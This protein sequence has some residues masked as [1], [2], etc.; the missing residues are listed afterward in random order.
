[1]TGPHGARGLV[2]RRTFL[3]GAAA[4]GTL[5]FSSRSGAA[6]P[7]VPAAMPSDVPP[8]DWRVRHGRVRQSVMTFVFKLPADTM[9]EAAA[10][11]GLAGIE[12]IG[13]DPQVLARARAKG[14][15][16][17]IGSTGSLQTGP[18]DRQIHQAYA[19]RV[20]GVI[21]TAAERG[22]PAIICFTGNRPEGVST[23]QGRRNCIEGFK[24]VAPYAAQ[25]T[26]DMCRDTRNRRDS[27][28]WMTGHPGYFGDDADLCADIVRA[29]DSPGLKLLF[30]I[31]HVQ[32]MNG[33]VIR[34]I[35]QYADLIG[36]VHTAGVPGRHE[37]DDRQELNYPAIMR[38]L[39]EVG[40]RGFVAHEFIPTWPDKLAA[41]RHAVRLCDVPAP[42]SPTAQPP[43]ASRSTAAVR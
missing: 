21:D 18:V 31:Y 27:S 6:E 17:T 13:S 29:V 5:G 2:N 25:K 1:M 34:R 36:H 39:L 7:A 10:R 19:E 23:E 3:A 43:R 37:L 9:I 24:L 22:L 15:T 26:V 38:A 11:M 12:G 8:E 40:Y 41:L 28:G 33:D 30:D 4:A 14:L 20:R 32:V 16:V 35:R 42:D